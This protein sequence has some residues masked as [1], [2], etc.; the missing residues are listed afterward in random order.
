MHIT[1]AGLEVFVSLYNIHIFFVILVNKISC[2]SY[3]L[4]IITLQNKFATMQ[5]EL[6]NLEKSVS[7]TWKS[8]RTKDRIKL[9]TKKGTEG[10]IKTPIKVRIK[11][12]TKE[13][14]KLVYKITC[15]CTSFCMSFG[16]SFVHPM[17]CSFVGHFVLF[18]VRNFIRP[19]TRPLF[20]VGFMYDG[21]DRTTLWR[22]VIQ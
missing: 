13:R 19:S 4:S 17:V 8:G 9:R 11:G 3:V 10:R 21:V 2:I 16:T 15:F 12:R 18:F 20:K 1:V 5:G 7:P 22:E 14:A 6:F